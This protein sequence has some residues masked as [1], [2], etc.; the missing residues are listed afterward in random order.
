MTILLTGADGFIGSH[1]LEQ[2]VRRGE[3]VRAMALYNSFGT[4]G[5][6]DALDPAIQDA[7]EI[8]SGDIRDAAFVRGAMK[9]CDRALNLAALIAIPY[10]YVAPES[11]V[12]TNVVGTLNMVQAA[13]DLGLSKLVHVST[14]EVY[15]TAQFVPITEAH[16]MHAQSPYAA[17][18]VGADQLALSF[19][20]SFATPI[21]IARPFNT[22]GPRQSTRAII[23]TVITQ[24]AAGQRRIELGALRPTR[25]FNFVEDTAAGLIAV[26]D[27]PTSVGEEINLGSGFEITVGDAAALIAEIMDAQIEIAW[28]DARMR[29]EKS[30]VDRLLACNKKARRLLD[31]RPRLEGREGLRAG[32]EKTT[33]WFR[34]P[35]NLARYRVGTYTL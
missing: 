13:R 21:A 24:I 30:E 29:P 28:S 25:D 4:R 3:R 8:V 22:Y 7:I 6:I 32:L 26:L 27:A 17:S 12:Q 18:K 19:F 14:S 11:Y 2:L 34:Q 9:G 23:P 5:W 10:S 16:P 20:R 31:W 15:G 35:Q 1:L 33:A